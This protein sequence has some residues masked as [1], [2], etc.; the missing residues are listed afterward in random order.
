MVYACHGVQV[1]LCFYLVDVCVC[2]WCV[3]GGSFTLLIGYTIPPVV[4]I[5]SEDVKVES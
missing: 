1:F 5:L 4:L 2:M 3:E